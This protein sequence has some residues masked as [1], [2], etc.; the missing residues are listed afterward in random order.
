MRRA[1]VEVL[2][3]VEARCRLSLSNTLCATTTQRNEAML[4]TTICVRN[5]LSGPVLAS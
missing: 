2:L 5:L 3:E 1:D 4:Q